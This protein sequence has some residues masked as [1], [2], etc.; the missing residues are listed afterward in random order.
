MKI[1]PIAKTC[2]SDHESLEQDFEAQDFIA[3]VRANQQKLTADLKPHY[4]FIVC[5]SGSSGSVVARRLAENRLVDV[6]LVEVGGSDDLPEVMEASKWPLNRASER[7]W[8][9]LG[10]PSR[11]LNGRS[12]PLHMG[13]VLGGG[14]S[15][16]AMAWAHG[17]KNDWDFFASEAGDS[18]WNYES[19]SKIYR[20]IEDWRGAPDPDYRGIGG[21]VLVQ[22]P[23]DPNPVAPAMV[24]GARSVGIPT[25]ESHNGRMME[26]DGGASLLE[27]RLRNGRRQSVFRT[28]TFPY[29]DRSNL[30]V[31]SRAMVTSLIF[32]GKR[33]T[34]VE[35][36]YGYKTHRIAAGFEVILSLGAM[37]TPKLLM[38]SGIGDQAEL[39]RFGIPL[40]QHLPGVGKN[41]Q[42]HVRSA[43]IWEY[44]EPLSPRNN[45]GEATFFWKSNPSL[46][47]PD[48][49]TV[50]VEVPFFSAETEARFKP[51]AGS[52][53]LLPSVVQPKSRGDIRLTGPKPLD[54]IQIHD[55]LLSHPDDMKAMIFGVEI[56][57]EIGNSA[58]LRPYV[59]RE[60][61]PGN[62]KGADLENFIRDAATTFSHQTC[63]A[64]MGRDSMS[65]VD[66]N[67]KVYGIDNLR[68]VDGSIMP[69]VTTGNTMAPCVVIG[70]RAGE[71]L[72]IEHKL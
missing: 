17:H 48:I 62:L 32:E 15:I 27:L 47:T 64:K 9:F 23:P 65:V 28:Y 2:S 41:F 33:A 39:Q 14:S 38:Q 35:I 59:K 57:R 25:F 55:N 52:W 12:I 34:G 13:K 70:E 6:L 50:Q 7:N 26:G 22:P 24:E 40:V 3:R 51:P 42:D 10:Q 66:G 19:V 67:L 56:C 54:P 49:Q 53:T 21:L 5:G 11:H 60:V 69:R 31:L 29:M 18:A 43:C 4:D 71:I 68:I 16:N 45:A 63:T 36:A 44:Q 1:E 46:S 8:G 37:H 20:R 72:R 30:T 61:M 58:A